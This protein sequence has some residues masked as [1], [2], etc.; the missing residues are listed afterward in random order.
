VI[1]VFLC[2]QMTDLTSV[3]VMCFQV[4]AKFLV[5]LGSNIFIDAYCYDM[6]S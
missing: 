4:G 3:E 2:L 6:Q 5:I 1:I